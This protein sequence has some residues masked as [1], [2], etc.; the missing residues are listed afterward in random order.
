MG[1][2]SLENRSDLHDF[3]IDVSL[4]RTLVPDRIHLSGC[5]RSPGALVIFLFLCCCYYTGWAKK[6][7]H[8]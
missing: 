7:G 8:F 1:S 5:L 2:F 3:I 4:I 6:L